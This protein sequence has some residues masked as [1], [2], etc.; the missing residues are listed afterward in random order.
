MAGT[1]GIQDIDLKRVLR[2][3]CGVSCAFLIAQLLAWPL[4]YVTPVLTALLLLDPAPLALRTAGK[5]LVTAVMSILAGYLI[6]TGLTPYPIIFI[7]AFGLLLFRL[8]L[9]LLMSG[10]HFIGITGALLG[11]LLMP[12]LVRVHPDVAAGVALGIVVDLGVAMM[13]SWVSFALFPVRSVPTAPSAKTIPLAIALGLSARLTWVA[14]PLFVAFLVFEW[15]NALTLIFAVLFATGM[16]SQGGAAQGITSLIGNVLLGG[17][18]MLLCYELLVAAPFLPFLGLM[19]MT[20]CVIFGAQ[21]LK[22]GRHRQIWWSGLSALLLLLG[23]ALASEDVTT[24][25]K[26]IDRGGMILL[27]T[28]YV[29]F[30]Y[31]FLDLVE[32]ALTKLRTKDPFMKVAGQ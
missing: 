28:L 30:A 27:A 7:L 26:L 10:A 25:G 2:F 4:A 21:I 5:V 20:L 24:T 6:A 12:V 22:G 31:N 14:M 1:S 18:T 13:I 32:H 29:V 19:I 9:Y 8:Y 16:N 23:S 15:T 3:A 17:A 11:C